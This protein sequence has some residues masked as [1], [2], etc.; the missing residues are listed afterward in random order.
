MNTYYHARPRHHYLIPPQQLPLPSQ[1]SWVSPPLITFTYLWYLWPWG[2]GKV[3]AL[4]SWSLFPFIGHH[5]SLPSPLSQATV[6]GSRILMPIWFYYPQN[7]ICV[8]LICICSTCMVFNLQFRLLFPALIFPPGIPPLAD[9]FILT[10]PV[11]STREKIYV[12]AYRKGRKD[13]DGLKGKR[14]A[15]PHYLHDTRLIYSNS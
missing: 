5:F 10:F 3:S 7:A 1:I 14:P 13:E 8:A 2:S 6:Q 9:S 15:W 12:N 11:S 4:L